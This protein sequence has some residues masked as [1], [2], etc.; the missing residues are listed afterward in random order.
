MTRLII[1]FV[2]HVLAV[3]GFYYLRVTLASS[4][5]DSDLILFGL[6]PV[7]TTAAYFVGLKNRL[8]GV[9]GGIG[10]ALLLALVGQSVGMLIGLNVWGA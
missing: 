1:I 4:F 9:A 10:V 3:V 7:V 8:E 2:T 5:F 6:I